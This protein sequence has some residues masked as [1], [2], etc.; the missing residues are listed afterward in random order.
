VKDERKREVVEGTEKSPEREDRQTAIGTA[1]L[2][3]LVQ[4]TS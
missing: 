1:S 2:P 3:P 4:E